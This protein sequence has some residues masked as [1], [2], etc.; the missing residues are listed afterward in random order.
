M[1]RLDGYVNDI[2]PRIIAIYENASKQEE[3][4]LQETLCSYG[5]ILLDSWVAWRTLR[6][7][8]RDADIDENVHKKWFQT[9]SSYTAS[10]IK[11][12]WRF[13][14]TVEE[15]VKQQTRKNLK[16]VFDNII[17]KKRNTSAHFTK[18]AEVTGQDSRLIKQLFEMFSKVFLL[19]ENYYFW[20]EVSL[21]LE[22]E[23]YRDF[24]VEFPDSGHLCRY[25]IL[26][27]KDALEDYYESKRFNILCK[28]EAG[29]EFVITVSEDGCEA[30]KYCKNSVLEPIYNDKHN[31][32]S[33]YKNK[34]YYQNIA[35]FIET[36]LKIWKC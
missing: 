7:I 23:G 14:D 33:F 5:W 31:T 10:Q 30:G 13:T 26:D 4:S 36:L 12:I 8:L 22:K 6:F 9:P 20:K 1:H 17:Q 32:Y 18:N 16:E 25:K 3:P 19:Y 24:E 35:L 21:K 34:G 15:F 27:F 11:A 2:E 29:E 28:N